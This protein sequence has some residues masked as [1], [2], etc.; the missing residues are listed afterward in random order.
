M[1][2]GELHLAFGAR[3]NRPARGNEVVGPHGLA[4]YE[5]SGENLLAPG[6]A[7]AAINLLKGVDLR[8]RE[9]VRAIGSGAFNDVVRWVEGAGTGI[10]DETVFEAVECVALLVDGLREQWKLF[11]RDRAAAHLGLPYPEAA[12]DVAGERDTG[13]SDHE[14][15]EIVRVAL[16]F[17]EALA[18]AGGA[19]NPVGV[20]RSGTIVGFYDA[21]GEH[22]GFV[23][24][25]VGEVDEFAV[26]VGI[27]G[28]NVSK[29]GER[30][31]CGV[32]AGVCRGGGKALA[33][34]VVYR[35]ETN[36]TGG[37]SVADHLKAVVPFGG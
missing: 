2:H 22:G 18:T 1:E 9:A 29:G 33:H 30:F 15:V 32:V 11:G 8:G 3:Q 21:F 14:T 24:R 37:A 34:G 28:R 26:A 25:E 7:R 4:A 31:S 27:L 16:G 13:G 5:L 6:I 23:D 36:S 12:R 17:L 10:V 20:F 19:S 35:A